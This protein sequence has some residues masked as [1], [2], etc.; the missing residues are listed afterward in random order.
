M[1]SVNWKQTNAGTQFFGM[2]DVHLEDFQVFL[3]QKERVET[4]SLLGGVVLSHLGI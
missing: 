2:T 1:R 4:V 3:W